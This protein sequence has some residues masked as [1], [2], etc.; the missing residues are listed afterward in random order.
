[1]NVTAPT[2]DCTKAVVAICVVLV[3]AAAVG[4]AGVPVSVGEFASTT[5]P[6]PVTLLD[7]AVV[8]RPFVSTDMLANV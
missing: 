8:T 4:A 2:A 7:A 3:L 6:V 1:M 5:E